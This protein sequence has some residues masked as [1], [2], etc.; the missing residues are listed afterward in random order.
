M[1]DVIDETRSAGIGFTGDDGTR[2]GFRGILGI[3]G[4]IILLGSLVLGEVFKDKK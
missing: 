4:G 3:V 2:P 1:V